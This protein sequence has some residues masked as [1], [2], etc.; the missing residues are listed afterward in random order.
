[1]FMAKFKLL[2]FVY[3]TVFKKNYF[4]FKSEITQIKSKCVFVCPSVCLSVCLFICLY[5]WFRRMA[6]RFVQ[7]FLEVVGKVQGSVS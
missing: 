6:G 4:A 2:F 1:M 5:A 7:L 3:C